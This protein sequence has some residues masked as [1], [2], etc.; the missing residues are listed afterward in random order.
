MPIDP[1]YLLIALLPLIG[2]LLLLGCIRLSGKALVTTGGRDLASLGFAISGLVAI[3]PGE[4]FFPKS[5]AGVFGPWVWVALIAFYSLI[6]SLIA[7]TSRPRLVIF[8]RSPDQM[9]DPLYESAKRL[10]DTATIEPEK[11]QVYLPKLGIRLKTSGHLGV[12]ATY[13][14]SFELVTSIEF[15]NTLLGHLR[16]QTI[17]TAKPTPRRGGAMIVAAILLSVI[18]GWQS[19]HNHQ[20][21]VQGF[22]EWLWR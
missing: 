15:W 4:L 3:G 21:L 11:L 5:A 18:V 20:Q 1:V 19:L 9:L 14:E 2:Y 12:D 10:D 17:K 13:V 22:R 8:G 7:L 16:D 6:V